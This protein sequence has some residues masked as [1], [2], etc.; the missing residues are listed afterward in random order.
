[1]RFSQRIGKKEVKVNFQTEDIDNDLRT[2]LWN[3]FDTAISYKNSDSVRWF[4]KKLWIDFFVKPTVSM[5][6][7]SLGDIN[8]RQY[9]DIAFKWFFDCEWFEVYDLLEYLVGLADYHFGDSF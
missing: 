6:L 4:Y 9:K 8:I 5:P 7:N 3:I 1:M 2:R